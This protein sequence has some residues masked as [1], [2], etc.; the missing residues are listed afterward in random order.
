MGGGVGHT[1][2]PNLSWSLLQAIAFF[3]PPK[4]RNRYRPPLPTYVGA[5]PSAGGCERS[6]RLSRSPLTTALMRAKTTRREDEQEA[7]VNI[8]EQERGH[9]VRELPVPRPQPHGDHQAEQ[10]GG[11]EAKVSH[12]PLGDGAHGRKATTG[13][14]G[15]RRRSP[16]AARPGEARVGEETRLESIVR[17]VSGGVGVGY[18]SAASPSARPARGR[19]R[20]PPVR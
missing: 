3:Q 9:Q 13:P 6:R 15:D 11:P 14:V 19:V 2:E 12:D 1:W 4:S 20:R 16:P 17:A 5:A 7:A 8:Q 18:G 10:N